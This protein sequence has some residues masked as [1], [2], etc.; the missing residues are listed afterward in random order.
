M[1][2]SFPLPIISDISRSIEIETEDA[3]RPGVDHRLVPETRQSPAGGHLQEAVHP[4]EK[5]QSVRTG[6]NL[7]LFNCCMCPLLEIEID[8]WKVVFIAEGCDLISKHG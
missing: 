6:K 1:N 5:S 4:R 2:A 3:G 8:I 7:C